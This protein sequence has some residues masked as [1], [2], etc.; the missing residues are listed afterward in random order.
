MF[1]AVL[2]VKNITDFQAQ[3]LFAALFA[4]VHIDFTIQHDKD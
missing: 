4:D 2:G 1:I 3:D